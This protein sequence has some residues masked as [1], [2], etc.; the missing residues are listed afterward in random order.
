MIPVLRLYDKH[1]KIIRPVSYIDFENEEVMF[2]AD[3]FGENDYY[4]GLDIVRNFDEVEIMQST[5]LKD[6]SGKEIYEGDICRWR[7]L[8]T[9]NDEI[10]E[11]VFVVVW[12]D[13]K[14][15]WYTQNEDGNFG[16]DLYEYTDDRDLGVIGN[17]YENID[18]L[19]VEK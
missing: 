19:E 11:D 10:L 3:D 9:F 15:A 8:E 18:L 2:Y 4:P 14:L 16:Y 6:E 5:G 13:E 1:L 17:I 12:N 7:D